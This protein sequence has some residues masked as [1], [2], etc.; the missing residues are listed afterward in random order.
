MD[1]KQSKL[2]RGGGDAESR[3]GG[4]ALRQIVIQVP[5]NGVAT[6][7]WREWVASL[8]PGLVHGACW[9]S[10]RIQTAVNVRCTVRTRHNASARKWRL[11]VQRQYRLQSIGAATENNQRIHMTCGS[12][13][14]GWRMSADSCGAAAGACGWLVVCVSLVQ[15]KLHCVVRVEV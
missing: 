1:S 4:G 10:V 15:P 8:I 2:D 11:Q 7:R 5:P 12:P 14:S 6:W 13:S 3:I 9:R